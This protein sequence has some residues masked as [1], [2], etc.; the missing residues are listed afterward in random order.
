MTDPHIIDQLSLY[1]DEELSALDR[2]KVEAHLQGCAGC[3]QRFEELQHLHA[4]LRALPPLTPPES[5]YRETLAKLERPAQQGGWSWGLSMKFVATAC[6]L[7]LVVL[8]TR[9]SRKPQEDL[10]HQALEGS[11]EKRAEPRPPSVVAYK[12][13]RLKDQNSPG[14]T[15][16][17][18]DSAARAPYELRSRDDNDFAKKKEKATHGEITEDVSSIRLGLQEEKAAAKSEAA[19]PMM[20]SAP[21]ST[22]DRVWRKQARDTNGPATQNSFGGLSQTSAPSQKSVARAVN[23]SGTSSTALTTGKESVLPRWRGFMSGIKT[24]RTAAIRSS[25]EWMTLWKEH[26]SFQVPLPTPLPIDFAHYTLITIFAGVK[27]TAGYG[28]QITEIRADPDQVV[29]LYRE[30]SPPPGTMQ[31][32]VITS[33]YE[34]RLIPKTTLPITFQKQ[35]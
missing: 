30:T 4:R 29:I 21:T 9:E 32:E 34:F 10:R 24:P 28:V 19:T 1:L 35:P 13:A 26:A 2:Q 8:A 20:A 27:P 33:P 22:G 6:V 7:M 25:E 14:E 12:N 23:G 18:T 15:K 11:F 5:F 31:A 16:I 3:R 17:E